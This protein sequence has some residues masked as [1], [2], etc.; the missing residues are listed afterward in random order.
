MSKICTLAIVTGYIV[1]QIRLECG[2]KKQAQL[3]ELFDMTHAAIGKIERGE[4]SA[5]LEFLMMLSDAIGCKASQIMLMV[6]QIAEYLASEGVTFIV[7]AP[8]SNAFDDA[9][10]LSYED[11]EEYVPLELKKAVRDLVQQKPTLDIKEAEQAVKSFDFNKV[12]NDP[13]DVT[14][15]A[16]L[17]GGPVGLG[18]GVTL[19]A[20]RFLMKNVN[21]KKSSN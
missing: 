6:E 21:T 5:S 8:T 17:L 11:I 1:N 13:V 14:T 19:L 3:S 18:I 4:A 15:I 9:D 7:H 20:S 16:M 10:I 2:F 12:L